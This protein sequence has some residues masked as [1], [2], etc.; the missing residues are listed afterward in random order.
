MLWKG[1]TVECK[2]LFDGPGCVDNSKFITL[3]VVIYQRLISA[4]IKVVRSIFDEQ[5]K[6]CQKWRKT[7]NALDEMISLSN[8]RAGGEAGHFRNSGNALVG[9][10]GNTSRLAGDCSCIVE[11]GD[12]A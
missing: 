12:I 10:I 7:A 4:F 8:G 5:Q 11:L 2:L 1:A 9:E 3:L 6:L